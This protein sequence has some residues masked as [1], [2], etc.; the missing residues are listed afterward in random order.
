MQP[1]KR[2]RGKKR[3]YVRKTP[4]AD[5]APAAELYTEQVTYLPGE[6]DPA[7]VKWG[8]ITFHANRPKEIEAHAEGSPSQRG[9]HQL[10]ENARKNKFFHVGEFDAA[11][12][13]EARESASLPKTSDQ[14]RAHVI[15]WLSKMSSE[16]ELDAKWISEESMR[17]ACGVGSDDLEW[18][19]EKIAP[20][21][22]E[23]RKA[24]LDG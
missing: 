8:G 10:I 18:L 22:F 19:G 3:P 21:R 15:G 14:Y 12:A 7:S 1:R 5:A 23:L 24:G 13:V 9:M 6:G 17:G 11:N 16:G 2:G 20:K 4:A